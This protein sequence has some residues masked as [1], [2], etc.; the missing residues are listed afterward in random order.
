[1]KYCEL[2]KYNNVFLQ[3]KLDKGECSI[4]TVTF[5]FCSSLF[6]VFLVS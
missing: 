4:K 1:M 5:T 6:Y 3:R 2:N